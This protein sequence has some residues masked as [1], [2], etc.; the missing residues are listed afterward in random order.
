MANLLCGP[1]LRYTY[2][3]KETSTW[4][5]SALIVTKGDSKPTLRLSLDGKDSERNIDGVALLTENGHSFWRFS[6]SVQLEDKELQVKYLIQGAELKDLAGGFW[7]PAKTETMRILFHSCNGF[8]ITVK[9]EDYTGP[10]LWADVMRI[11]N[12]ESAFHVMI[13]GGDQ[14]YSDAVRT[15]G[16][17]KAWAKITD[18]RKRSKLPVTDQLKAEMDEWYF[19]NYTAWYSTEPF[20]RAVA[21]IPACNIYDDHDIIDGF[22]SYQHKYHTAPIFMHIGAVAYKYY[23]LFQLQIPPAGDPG[24]EDPSFVLGPRKGPYIQ[25]HSRSICT[26]LGPR[27]VFYGLDC[28]T[29]RTFETICS[30][31]TYD[32]MFERLGREVVKGKTA[33]LLLLL[34]VPIFYPRMVFAERAM[35]NR[36]MVGP[37]KAIHQRFGLLAGMFNQTDGNAE[38]LDDLNDHWCAHPHKKERNALVKRL[39]A[40]A[41]EKQVRVTILSGDVHL[42][43]IGRVFT[44]ERFKIAQNKDHRYMVNIISSAIT[45]APPPAALANMLDR[46]NKMHHFDAF[47]DEDLMSI[48]HEN[49]DG[50]N[51]VMNSTTM[52]ARNYC[53]IVEH[54]G[55]TDAPGGGAADRPPADSDAG[56]GPSPS[57]RAHDA[58]II[59]ATKPRDEHAGL[60][61]NVVVAQN[62]ENDAGKAKNQ[63]KSDELESKFAATAEKLQKK[64]AGM[65]EKAQAAERPEEDMVPARQQKGGFDHASAAAPVSGTKRAGALD[66]SI[67]VEINPKDAL[68]RT[69]PYGFLIPA[70][71][72]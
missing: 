38:L 17:L 25:E 35:T 43:A 45:N 54:A 67:R 7:V 3:D 27:V 61:D 6:M 47:T 40:F 14:V 72:V 49:A 20:C 29:D 52:P 18:P 66:V 53:V 46:R 12:E 69:R 42:A 22:G 37:L 2:T 50:A 51:N 56:P 39:Q 34:G 26:A 62:E 33:H 59:D 10:A 31:G 15:T 70:L 48:F 63:D 64:D 4:N 21:A 9:Q 28:R 23:T 13:G 5:G 41:Q 57:P 11:H 1:L 55:M 65:Q 44:K 8:D 16:P 32:A 68:G 71:E 60:H 58:E 30:A 24:A 19:N 36:F